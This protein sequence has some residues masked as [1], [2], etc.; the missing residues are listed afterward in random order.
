VGL[1]DREWISV[2]TYRILHSSIFHWN[3]TDNHENKVEILKWIC[4]FVSE[5]R[6]L[7]KF[8]ERLYRNYPGKFVIFE[9]VQPVKSINSKR[10]QKQQ[11]NLNLKHQRRVSRNPPSGLP[12][13]QIEEEKEDE[14]EQS[15]SDQKKKSRT[16]FGE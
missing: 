11:R 8:L 12:Y 16:S 5:N 2:V 13:F 14:E 9:E 4:E 15:Q 3:T 10:L 1:F 6:K 7:Q